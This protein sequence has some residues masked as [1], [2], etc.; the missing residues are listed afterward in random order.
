MLYQI[1]DDILGIIYVKIVGDRESINE[2]KSLLYV[3]TLNNIAVQ[4]SVTCCQPL[5][6]QAMGRN[7]TGN[8]T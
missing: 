6:H 1:N 3:Q 7:C 8:S 5:G 4:D 2:S